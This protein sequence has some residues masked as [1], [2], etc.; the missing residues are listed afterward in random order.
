MP[1]QPRPRRI[2]KRRLL[3]LLSVLAFLG[4]AAFTLGLVAGIASAIPSLDAR[5]RQAQ[6]RNGVVYDREGRRVLAVLRGSESRVLVSPDGISDRMKLAIVAVEDRRFWE[7]RGIDLRG[8]GRALWADLRNQRV[9][10]G[11]S[12]ITQRFVKN[13]YVDDQRSLGR[14]VREAALA[15]Q[16]ERDHRW[17]KQKILAEYLNTIYFGNG[18]YGI[19]QAA[20]AYFGHGASTLDLAESALLAGIPADPS[21]Y[22]PVLNPARARARRLQVLQAMVEVGAISSREL[23]ASAAAPLPRPQSVRLPGTQALAAPYFTNYVKEQLVES[24]GAKRVFGGGLRVRT[25]IDLG[26]QE[27]ARQAIEKWLPEED[28]PSA[29]LVAL[30]AR[31]GDVLAMVGGRNFRESQ[32]NLAVQGERQ[33]GSAFKPFVLAT[34]L[35]AGVSPATTFVSKPLQISLGDRFWS[36][37]N[38]E[39]A[40]LGSV[41]L[42]TATVHSDNAVYAQLTALLGP[43]AVAETARRLGVRSPLRGYFSIALGAQAVNPLE[44]ARSYAAFANGGFRIDGSLR[45]LENQPRVIESVRTPSS[46]LANRARP[47]RVLTPRT[48]SFVNFLL[49]QTVEEGTAVRA[50]LPGWSVAGK[51]GTTEEYGDAWFVGYT[52]RLVV[53]VWVG[54]PDELRPMLTEFHGDPVAGGTY[55]A[56]IWKS[57]MERALPDLGHASERFASPPSDFSS[58]RQVVQRGGRLQLDNGDCRGTISIVYFAG[59]GPE[60]TA[61][62]RPNEVEVPSVVGQTLAQATARLAQQ[63]LR[64]AVVYKWA[65]PLQR[66]DVV[67]GQIPSSGRLSS[68]DEVT[69]VLAKPRNGLVPDLEGAHLEAARGKLRRLGLELQI[70]GYAEG[71]PG[72][73]VSQ[74]PAAGLAAEAGMTVRLVLGRE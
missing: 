30:D 3:G 50:G 57:F 20:R 61:D 11:G 56:L 49:Q 13:V 46:L 22:D 54:Y 25:T 1:S 21:G 40:Y 72:R 41:D 26:L 37:E 27:R 38:Y 67:L 33:P 35:E 5:A 74:Q 55:P 53:A 12:T 69:L 68:F 28:G 52:P 7:H 45:R 71:P 18:A 66:V 24:F 47:E 16:L 14:K 29:A 4:L 23:R 9:V 44:L 15:W 70:T 2:R 8:I 17:S 65:K 73:V 43:K 63:P 10:Q 34:A 32:F 60:T 19:Q 62:C 31:N 64:P 58:A 48:A 36:V 39:D 6:E 59:T 51:T 42:E